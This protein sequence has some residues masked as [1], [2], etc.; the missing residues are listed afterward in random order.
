[1]GTLFVHQ[2]NAF[3]FLI[4]ILVTLITTAIQVAEMCQKEKK[5]HR[6]YVEPVYYKKREKYRMPK[7]NREYQPKPYKYQANPNI[8]RE[9]TVLIPPQINQLY[10]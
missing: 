3:F 5:V 7:R 1:M 10:V 9:R 2:G 8:P 4:G 6:E